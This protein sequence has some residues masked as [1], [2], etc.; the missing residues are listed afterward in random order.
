MGG[1]S[2]NQ[3]Y[4]LGGPGSIWGSLCFGKLHITHSIRKCASWPEC[5]LPQ[6]SRPVPAL[7]L[8]EPLSKLL[9]YNSLGSLDYSSHVE[10]YLGNPIAIVVHGV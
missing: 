8:H 7:S 1:V 4:S 2:E 5:G 6:G 9:L 10:A 3:G